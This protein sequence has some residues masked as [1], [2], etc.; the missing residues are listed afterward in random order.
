MHISIDSTPPSEY[1]ASY[2][3]ATARGM[4]LTTE[5]LPEVILVWCYVWDDGHRSPP[6]L[7]LGDLQNVRKIKQLGHQPTWN[8]ARHP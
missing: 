3:A 7:P 1:D 2:G 6:S 8:A 5:V 4:A